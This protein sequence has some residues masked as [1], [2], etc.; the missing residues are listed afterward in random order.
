MHD[1]DVMAEAKALSPRAEFPIPGEPDVTVGLFRDG[2]V[3]I[4]CGDDPVFQ[5]D[6][7]GRLRRAFVGGKLLRAEGRTLS[8]LTRERGDDATTL[9]RIDLSLTETGRFLDIAAARLA[10]FAAVLGNGAVASRAEPADGVEELKQTVLPTLNRFLS[11]PRVAP[12]IV[13]R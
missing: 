12:Q 7:D 4:Y 2:R 13:D 10:A 8:V 3:A 11:A 5:L 6:P 1:E 9:N